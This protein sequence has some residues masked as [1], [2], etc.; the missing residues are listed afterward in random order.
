VVMAR[1]VPLAVAADSLGNRRASWLVG[2]LSLV[3]GKI[4]G[5]LERNAG[6]TRGDDK[7]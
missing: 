3:R 6:S 5:V 1:Y 4:G 7:P 2:L